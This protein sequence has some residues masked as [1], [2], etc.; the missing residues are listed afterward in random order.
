MKKMHLR[1]LLCLTK[2]IPSWWKCRRNH[3]DYIW[4][5]HVFHT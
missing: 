2:Y 3:H 4:N 5:G 1:W